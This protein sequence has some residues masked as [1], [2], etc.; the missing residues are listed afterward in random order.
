MQSDSKKNTTIFQTLIYKYQTMPVQARAAFW[1]LVCS[2]L[3]KGI[4]VIT[5]PIFTRLLSTAEYG[6]FSV[7]NSWKSIVNIIVTLNM[8]GGVYMQSL[9]KF[10]EER[11]KLSSSLQGLT[12]LLIAAWTVVYLLFRRFV[13]GYF[14]LTTTQMLLMLLM[15]WTSS[16]FSFWAAEQRVLMNYKGLVALTIVVSIAK[17]V[18]GIIFVCNSEDKVTARIFG[19]ALV[20]I[21]A[22]SWLF[23]AQI[24][25]GKTLVSG[26]FWKY[27][28]GL[29]VPL[30]PHYLSQT[31]LATAD[32]IMINN[33]VSADKAGI[34]SL[35]YSISQI[36]T[37]FGTAIMDSISP[38]I[39]QKIKDDKAE[40]IPRIGYLTMILVAG[41]NVMFILLAPEV[42]KIFATSDYYEAIWVIPPI[43]LSVL[44]TYA[45]DFFA[46][47]EFYFEKTGYISVATMIGAALNVALNYVFINV[48]GYIA[49][50][51]T[52]LICYMM[53]TCLHYYFMKKLCKE[54]M[55]DKRIF[56]TR[57][58][59]LITVVS[60]VCGF[61]IMALYNL[62][63]IRYALAAVILVIIYV[64]RD[65][66]LKLRTLK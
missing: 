8:S 3:Q 27:C 56:D 38:W 39:F 22:F 63:L 32:R 54:H 40:D 64:K 47:F 14:G 34:Y 53:Y 13:D 52:T 43:A 61:G 21:L 37:L 1:F 28:L 66:V 51:Y 16:V 25:K 12:T 2:F 19:L 31:L 36:M 44:F 33:M 5:T 42:V 30:I 41:L 15:I 58:L 17:P 59:L 10:D 24:K 11:D 65:F 49:A 29:S 60:L 45:Y 20:E 48:F 18:L 6:Q 9:V 50:G 23:F 62:P 46:K 4:S 7:F 26:K 57:F 35:A 55:P